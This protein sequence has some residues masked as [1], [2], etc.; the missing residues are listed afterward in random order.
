MKKELLKKGIWLF[1]FS[2]AM[3]FLESSVVVYLREIYYPEG[4]S[5]PI[6]PMATH[7][8][9]T[10]LLREAATVIML[11]SLGAIIGKTF[12]ERFSAFLFSFAVWDIFYY[13]FLKLI[14]NWPESF[15]TWDILFLIPMLWVSPVLAPLIISFLMISFAVVIMYFRFQGKEIIIQW[16]EWVLLITGSVIVI[17]SFTRDSWIF[18]WCDAL[19]LKNSPNYFEFISF[20][21]PS[22]FSW[23]IFGFGAMIIISAIVVFFFRNKYQKIVLTKF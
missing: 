5:L 19:N 16:Y 1:V 3:G 4:F 11:I 12:A 8:A 21:R 22:D 6:K 18:F 20:Y 14:L 10:E 23:L 7:L 15:F 2:V 17:F 9:L 13:V